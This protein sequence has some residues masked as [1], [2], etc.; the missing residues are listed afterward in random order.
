MS[1]PARRRSPGEYSEHGD[2]HDDRETERARDD[3]VG[4]A[5]V[6]IHRSNPL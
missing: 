6:Q 3:E 5:E 4:V 2:D 1:L